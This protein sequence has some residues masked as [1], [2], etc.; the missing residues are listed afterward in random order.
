MLFHITHVHA[1]DKC[2][3]RD[4]V[5][6]QATYGK[7]IASAGELGVRLVGVWVDSPAHTVFMVAEAERVEQLEKLLG[8]VTQIGHADVKPVFDGLT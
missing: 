7:M 2:P 8:P 1:I 3:A 6:L 5:L 4:P